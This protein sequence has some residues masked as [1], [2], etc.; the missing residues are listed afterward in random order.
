[1]TQ[2]ILACAVIFGIGMLLLAN[3]VWTKWYFSNSAPIDAEVVAVKKRTIHDK[4]N[5]RNSYSVRVNYTT[6][7][8]DPIT[9]HLRVKDV[10]H[11]RLPQGIIDAAGETMNLVKVKDRM[12]EAHD[13]S[14]RMLA[15][16]KSKDEVKQA[17]TELYESRREAIESKTEDLGLAHGWVAVTIPTTIPV[18]VSKK[19]NE[20]AM[21]YSKGLSKTRS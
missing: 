19:N 14:S 17:I 8:G 3:F 16:G 4:K 10:Y 2:E 18:I 6:A 7:N 15:E 5:N 11:A 13:I 1:M 9:T 12:Q 21:L 20:K